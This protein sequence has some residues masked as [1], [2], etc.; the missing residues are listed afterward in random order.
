MSVRKNMTLVWAE[1]SIFVVVF[2]FDGAAMLSDLDL[3]PTRY[4]GTARSS[5][6]VF[7][8]SAG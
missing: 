6:R 3:S 5:G 4:G 1:E 8:G 2:T 7:R